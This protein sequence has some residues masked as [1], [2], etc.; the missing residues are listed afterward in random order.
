M[1]LLL[2]SR[3]T[4]QILTQ[5]VTEIRKSFRRIKSLLS[6]YEVQGFQDQLNQLE[7]QTIS[8]VVRSSKSQELILKH[9]RS[10]PA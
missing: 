9:K 8:G 3:A 4:P 5:D 2:N 1:G 6:Y 7:L 10:E